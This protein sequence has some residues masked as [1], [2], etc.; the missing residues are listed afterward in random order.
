MILH[1]HSD[2]SLLSEPGENIKAGGYHYLSTTFSDPKRDPPK[3]PPINVPIHVKCMTMRNF[4]A[5]T[6]KAK[7]GAFFCQLSESLRDA[8]GAHIDGTHPTTHPSS[9]G[10]L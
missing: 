8:H 4:L 5:S 6:M 9:D 1:I 3:Q 7:L 10:Q 2:A